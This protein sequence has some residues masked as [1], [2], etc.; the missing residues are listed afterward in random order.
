MAGEHSDPRVEIEL[1][2]KKG[3]T[4]RKFNLSNVLSQHTTYNIAKKMEDKDLSLEEISDIVDV[5]LRIILT[6]FENDDYFQPDEL[7]AFTQ[8]QFS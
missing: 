6:V 4:K 5:P 1:R 7:A 8:H 3:N 2:V